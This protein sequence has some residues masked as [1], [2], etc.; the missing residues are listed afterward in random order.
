MIGSMILGMVVAWYLWSLFGWTPGLGVV[1]AG[2][3][4]G[5]AIWTLSPTLLK[6]VLRTLC[7]RP[8][9]A[10]ASIEAACREPRAACQHVSQALA[11]VEQIFD[12][13]QV[14]DLT[15]GA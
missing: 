2:F 6:P 12:S 7:R 3:V 8:N 14:T 4:L 1:V 5:G 11:D 10:S 15:T 9:F 13:T